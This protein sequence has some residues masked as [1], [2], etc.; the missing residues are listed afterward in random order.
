MGKI[1]IVIFGMNKNMKFSPHKN[2]CYTIGTSSSRFH[3]VQ[4]F[5]HHMQLFYGQITT[6]WDNWSKYAGLHLGGEGARGAFA[7][8]PLNLMYTLEDL[9]FL[10]LCML[11]PLLILTFHDLPLL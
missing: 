7:T 3:V 6:V 4:Y 8:P 2:T 9:C 11:C 1:F 10:V 5:H